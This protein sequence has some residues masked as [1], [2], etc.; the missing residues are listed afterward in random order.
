M[1]VGPQVFTPGSPDSGLGQGRAFHVCQQVPTCRKD[2]ARRVLQMAD[3]VRDLG[4]LDRFEEL[5]AM[6]APCIAS[7]PKPLFDAQSVR[8]S[9]IRTRSALAGWQQR[10]REQV[11]A[12]YPDLVP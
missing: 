5:S 9:I 10:C 3:R 7:D 8:D 2:Y 4:L 6:L 1:P 12:E 11:G